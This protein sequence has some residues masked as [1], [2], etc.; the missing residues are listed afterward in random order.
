MKSQCLAFFLPLLILAVAVSCN[1]T[2][3]HEERFPFNLMESA[4][5]KPP[6]GRGAATGF[7]WV[8]SHEAEAG[9]REGDPLPAA[10][11][12]PLRAGDL[13]AYA[14]I[15]LRVSNRGGVLDLLT[16]WQIVK[17]PGRWRDGEEFRETGPVGFATTDHRDEAGAVHNL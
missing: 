11:A 13:I 12:A 5:S 16:P 2:G 17:S 8:V 7:E 10:A 14:G 4:P 1:H 3:S 6:E 9:T 15:E